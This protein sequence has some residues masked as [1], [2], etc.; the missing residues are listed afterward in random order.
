M[1]RQLG[2]YALLSARAGAAA[3]IPRD[4]I[5]ASIAGLYG[6]REAGAVSTEEGCARRCNGVSGEIYK[7]YN[8]VQRRVQNYPFYIFYIFYTVPVY[9]IYNIS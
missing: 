3:S 9:I 1:W 8:R 6:E 2:K 4:R 5:V 7:R